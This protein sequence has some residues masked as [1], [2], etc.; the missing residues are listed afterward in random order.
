MATLA[1]ELE[2]MFLTLCRPGK[3]LE[4]MYRV[5]PENLPEE[6]RRLDQVQQD[7]EWHP[8]GSV[9]RHTFHVVDA[10]A[11]DMWGVQMPEQ[12][13]IRLLFAALCHDTGKW[14]TTRFDETKQRWCSPRHA[15]AGVLVTAVFLQRIG[16]ASDDIQYVLPLVREHMYHVNKGV[17]EAAV[18]RLAERLRPATLEDLLLLMYA[19]C[20]GRPPLPRV[21]PEHCRRFVTHGQALGLLRSDADF[22]RL[23]VRPV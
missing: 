1:G 18:A 15:D 12:R 9:L 22:E 4:Q 11:D 21:L 19:D 17:S 10:M 3:M 14:M 7:P 20:S 23:F 16:V 2:W 6:L 5:G 13:R 8:E